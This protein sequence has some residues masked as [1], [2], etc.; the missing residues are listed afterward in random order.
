M[1]KTE[2]WGRVLEEVSENVTESSFRFFKDANIRDFTENPPIVYIESYNK[3]SSNILKNRYMDLLRES[4]LDVTGLN[5]K[6]IVKL[7]SEYK[8]SPQFS[9]AEPVPKVIFNEG[10]R[11]EMIFDPSFTFSNFI[12]GECNEY[13]AAIC[14]AIAEAPGKLYNPLFIYGNSGLGK[15][16][17]LNAVGIYLLEHTDNIRVLYVEAETFAN[18]FINSLQNNKIKEFNEKY[19]KTDVLLIDDIQFFENKEK[20]QVEFFHT[21]NTL[22]KENKQVIIAGDRPPSN[23]TAFDERLRSRFLMK[24]TAG[25]YSPDYETRVAILRKEAEKKNI[26]LNYDVN[27]IIEFISD[28]SKDNIR[29]LTGNFENVID[30]ARVLNQPP[31]LSFA[32]RILQDIIKTGGNVT[33]QKIKDVVCKYYNITIDDL[34]AETRK[35]NIAYPRQIAMYLCRNMTDYSLPRIGSIFGNK[36]YTTVKHA[37]DKISGEVKSNTSLKEEIDELINRINNY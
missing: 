25:V 6:I 18:D 35:S 7:T 32:K 14:K 28:K 31:T 4:F 16:H 17:L 9:K 30:A 34:D 29:E 37:C 19:R 10:F 13:A 33:P 15:T 11:G 1:E 12:V 27:E 5:Y 26:N 23:L 8:D 24:T 36:H 22:I 2:L 20:T 3:V 21:F